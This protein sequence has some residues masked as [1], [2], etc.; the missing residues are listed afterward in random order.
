MVVSKAITPES[1]I[2]NRKMNATAQ[3]WIDTDK[4]SCRDDVERLGL[5][6]ATEY[7]MELIAGRAASGDKRWEGITAEDMRAALAEKLT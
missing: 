2:K 3:N 5:D 6:G 1:K 7:Q 4:T